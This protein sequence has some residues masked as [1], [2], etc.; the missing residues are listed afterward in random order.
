MGLWLREVHI[1][2]VEEVKAFN[3]VKYLGPLSWLSNPANEH[4]VKDQELVDFLR[5]NEEAGWRKICSYPAKY[6]L[7]KPMHGSGYFACKV[8]IRQLNG[9]Y[10][11]YLYGIHEINV[12]TTSC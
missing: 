1:P 6:G 3:M 9:S 5:R 12:V 10:K 4:I 11:R 2:T 8:W 7:V